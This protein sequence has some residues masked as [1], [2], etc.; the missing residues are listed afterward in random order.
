MNNKYQDALANIAAIFISIACVSSLI[1]SI[2]AVDIIKSII[3]A[4]TSVVYLLSAEL[5]IA[6]AVLALASKQIKLILLYMLAS[7][8][9][10]GLAGFYLFSSIVSVL[11]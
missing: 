10:A 8:A 4:M 7:L 1:V 2:F 6:A 5:F 11:F 3:H 9:G